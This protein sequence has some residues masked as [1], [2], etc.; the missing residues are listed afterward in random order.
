[1]C[2]VTS[3][4]ATATSTSAAP[5]ATGTAVC[6]AGTA[7]DGLPSNF[8]ELCEFTCEYGYCP[9]GVCTCTATGAGNTAPAIT[10]ESG[11]PLD[12][13]NDGY[14]GLCSYACNHGFCPDDACQAC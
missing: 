8:E 13:E 6:T 3:P 14:D 10:G 4:T 11:C 5:S 9:D 7:A 12:G 1:M 2:D